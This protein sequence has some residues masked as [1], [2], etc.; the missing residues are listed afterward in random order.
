[1]KRRLLFVV[2]VALLSAISNTAAENHG[3]VMNDNDLEYIDLVVGTGAVA[4]PESVVVVHITGWLDDNGQKGVKII[5]SRDRDNPVSFKVGTEKV[6]KAWSQ[7][8]RGMR[9]GGKRRLMVPP[10]LGYGAKSV[11]DLI[12]P[13]ADLI[14][15]IE[16]LDVR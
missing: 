12:P 8:V 2:I 16:L 3:L 1:M 11:G 5:S 6:M 7:G 4:G 9:V 13:N 15:D 14:F 10:S